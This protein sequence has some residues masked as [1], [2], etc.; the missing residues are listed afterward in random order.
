MI[1]QL[2]DK[3]LFRKL[4]LHLRVDKRKKQHG[5]TYDIRGV[6]KNSG[7]LKS[8]DQK[9]LSYIVKPEEKLCYI[10][11]MD[12]LYLPTKS[13]SHPSN[14]KPIFYSYLHHPSKVSTQKLS[15]SCKGICFL[16]H[17]PKIL[18]P[19]WLLVYHIW[20]SFESRG[21]RQCWSSTMERILKLH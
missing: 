7:I 16:L 8:L 21:R 12:R 6:E 4:K 20:D 1:D 2:L 18:Q 19:S 13:N 14:L 3:K 10:L 17:L 11:L 9:K 15:W 5:S